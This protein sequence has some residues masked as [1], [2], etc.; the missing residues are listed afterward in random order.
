MDAP[1]GNTALLRAASGRSASR[2]SKSCGI[3]NASVETNL[4][5]LGLKDV[6]GLG[7]CVAENAL[8]ERHDWCAGLLQDELGRLHDVGV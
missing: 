1:F 6:P 4:L 8:A 5:R 2:G 7:G 3:G